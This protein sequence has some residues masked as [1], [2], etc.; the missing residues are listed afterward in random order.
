MKTSYLL[1]CL[2]VASTVTPAVHSQNYVYATGNPSFSTQIPIE[3]GFINVNNGEIHMEIPLATHTQRGRIPLNESLVYDSRIWQIVQGSGSSWSPTNLPNSMGGW[4]LVTNNTVQAPTY[5]SYIQYMNCGPGNSR[6]PI[7]DTFWN[8]AWADPGGTNHLF[9]TSLSQ[10]PP[11]PCNPNPP[12][13][14]AYGSAMDGSGYSMTATYNPSTGGLN[15]V[16]YDVHGNEVYPVVQDSNGNYFSSDSSGN[17]VDTLGR[18]PVK[19]TRNGTQITYSVL[20]FNGARNNYTVTTETV[21]YHTAFGQQAVADVSGSFTAIQSIELPDGSSYSFTYDSGTS[22]GNYGELKSVTLPS[23]GVI[24]YT[25]QN[26]LD[27]FENEN[28]WIATHVNND[29]TTTFYPKTISYCTNGLNCQVDMAVVDPAA[30]NSYTFYVFLLNSATDT[31]AGSWNTAVLYM[32]GALG[33]NWPPGGGTELEEIDTN[34]T[35]GTITVN[36]PPNGTVTYTVPQT[37]TVTEY[38]TNTMLTAKTVTNLNANGSLPT[39]IQTWD[40]YSGS[41]PSNPTIQ[42]NFTYGYVFDL[43][44]V[45][46]VTDGSGDL[47]SET[48]YTYD[49]GTPTPKTGLPNHNTPAGI[50]GNL[51]T[52]SQWINSSGSSLT[53]TATYDN[54]GTLLTKTDPNGT[55]TYGYDS[56]DTFATS[57]TPPTPSSGVVLTSLNTVDFS[58]GLLTSTTD[59]N[60]QQTTYKNYDA[61]GRVGEID[62]PDNGKSVFGYAP[63]DGYASTPTEAHVYRYQNSSTYADTETIYDGYGRPIRTATANGQGS[64]PWYEQDTCYNSVGKVSFQSY[65]YQAATLTGAE[66]CSGAGDA[67]A[68]DAL[69]RLTTATHGDGTQIVSSYTGRAAETTDENGVSRI[70]QGDVF[71]RVTAACEITSTAL[72]GSGTPASCGLD[73]AG[74]GYLTTYSYSL[75]GHQATVNQGTQQRVFQTDFIGRPVLVQEPES[76]QT[77]YSYAYNSNPVG[78]QVTRVRPQANQTNSSVTTTTTTQY[79]TLGR[80]LTISYSNGMAPYKYYEYD[81]S[82]QWG[83]TLQ[84]P[85][86]RLVADGTAVTGD[87]YGYDAMGRVILLEECTPSTCGSNQFQLAYT[88]DWLGNVLTAGDGSWSGFVTSYTYSPANE[89]LSVTSSLNNS[90]HPGNLVSNVQNGPSGP[91]SWQ[92]GNGETGVRQYDS[93]GRVTGGWICQGSAQ[94]NCSGGTQVYGF[95]SGWKGSY[96]TSA[97]DSVLGQSNSYAYDNLGR[98]AALTG[99]PN[100]FTYSFDRWGNRWAQTATS[101]SGPQ[102]NLSFNTSNN[103]ITNTGYNYDA[104]GNMYYDGTNAYTYDA[105]GNVTGVSGNTNA[106]YVYDALNQRVRITPGSGDPNEFIFNAGGQRSVT[107]DPVDDYQYGKAY[108]GASPVSYYY[109][110]GQTHFEY[111]DWEGTE[112]MRTYY[113]GSVEATFQSL[114]WGD[115]FS[116]S[117]PDDDPYHFAGLDQDASSLD[118]AQYREYFNVAGRWMSPDPYGGS[119]DSSNPQSLNRYAYVLNKPL[120]FTD[121]TG[122]KVPGCNEYR[123][124]YSGYGQ[125]EGGGYLPDGGLFNQYIYGENGD[126]DLGYPVWAG[127]SVPLE[128]PEMAANNGNYSY[129]KLW[130]KDLKS[131]FVDTGLGTIANQMDP[132]SPSASNAVQGAVDSASQAALAGAAVHSVERGLTVPL[133]SSIVRAGAGASEALGEASGWITITNLYYGI[134]KAYVAEWKQCGW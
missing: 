26:F 6:E 67:F 92:I 124:F 63:A 90:T 114:P 69:A 115:G 76:G 132:F 57:V 66:V 97:S 58:S 130:L 15:C 110:D 96:L 34:Y 118:H 104:A 117:G 84:N 129:F 127:G 112:R 5:S 119:Y 36:G 71:G 32:Q 48:T 78:L 30:N 44:T 88:Y 23:G 45:I 10:M 25:W 33:S 68:Y 103:Q 29:G 113:D 102:P 17:L 83:V 55:T 39:S 109:Y 37:Q 56:T 47:V 111:Q 51:T 46:K 91:L 64:N 27:P 18:T 2:L 3:N 99:N 125:F 122:L 128:G 86:G 133:R 65:P 9:D 87:I 107:F 116:A 81:V 80:P 121:P 42:T 89:V 12:Y 101:G 120:S 13:Y 94:P 131:C 79:D 70:T 62:Y 98:L 41:A 49:Q 123:C 21:Y 54:A 14:P 31:N 19:T 53:T 105:E 74:T 77:T 28:R 61:F 40:Y 59:P 16:V 22:S 95:T 24:Q 108:W 85:K 52:M 11:S 134:G 7:L 82:P 100:S 8:L 50:E 73:I 60:G 75:A 1:I 20:G 4:R 106:Q 35:W 43:P 93:M 126:Y 38:L 72:Q